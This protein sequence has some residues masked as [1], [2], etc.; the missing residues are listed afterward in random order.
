MAKTGPIIVLDPGKERTK[1]NEALF[2]NINAAKAVAGLVQSTLGPKGMDKMLINKMGQVSMT[3]DGVNIL[4]DIGI[5]H[6]AAKMV[7]EVARS[8]EST[9][10]DG[11]TSSVILSAA[12]LDKAE[13]LVRKGIHPSAIV[14]GYRIAETKALELLENSAIDVAKGDRADILKKVAMTSIT[15]K[16]PDVHKEFLADLCVKAAEIVEEDGFVDVR[17]KII[18]VVELQRRIDESE[19]IE[20]IALNT[21]ALS[22]KA[23]KRIENPKIALLDTEI[24]ANKTKAN[25]VMVVSSPE[26]RQKII[27]GE[28]ND[29]TAIAKKIVD[30]G[31]TAVF[32]TKVV[33]GPVLE[34]LEKHDV[35]VSRPMEEKDIENVSYATGAKII[36]NPKEITENDLGSADLLERD[37]RNGG[38]KTYIRGGHNSTV[39]TIV[40]RGETL[41]HAD[42]VD[43]A[44]DDALWVIKSVIE[45]GKIVAGGGASEMAVALGLS[46]Y[47]PKAGGYDQRVISAYADALEELPKTLIRNG[48][49]DVIDLS[50]A[51]RAEHTK[52]KNAGINVF[53]GKITDMLEAGVVDPYRV[54]ANT[55]KAATEAAIMIL[56]IDDMLRATVTREIPDAPA[57][58]MAATYN[59]MAPPQ[60]N[61]RR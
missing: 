17:T 46:A 22:R 7:V 40:V 47:A 23:P 30:T 58:H 56:R 49:L 50:L 13:K 26:E 42:S 32:S 55:I 41:Q 60:M 39:A 21:G 59:G 9:A 1:G 15:G 36:R 11:T 20:G 37:T 24:I 38:G 6:P 3:N 35:F 51:L 57:S 12:L 31:A 19:V 28:R 53:T 16:A 18:R 25:S 4:K 34:Y 43:T 5:E 8:V 45:D 61:E 33:R 2:M 10:G 44:L 54:K 48:G 14:K 29:L 52:N 27:D